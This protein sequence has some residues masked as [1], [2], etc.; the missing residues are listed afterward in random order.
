MEKYTK[1]EQAHLHDKVNTIKERANLN[2]DTLMQ[3]KD[4]GRKI[5]LQK[6]VL[7]RGV[8]PLY[9]MFDNVVSQLS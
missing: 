4:Q 3:N 7:K 5:E 9:I 2:E 6:Y 1:L 8:V